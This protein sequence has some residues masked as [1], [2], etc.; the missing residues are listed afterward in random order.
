M[1]QQVKPQL[2]RTIEAFARI[3]RGQRFSVPTRKWI[4]P[5]DLNRSGL[6]RVDNQITTL[7]TYKALEHRMHQ[8]TPDDIHLLC[9][10]LQDSRQPKRFWLW[11]WNNDR[12]VHIV[13]PAG[14]DIKTL[15]GELAK[16]FPNA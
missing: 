11:I 14:T 5:V 1:A 13:E 3:N 8:W 9:A 2:K 10:V 6:L 7:K 4:N 12:G 15:D 16:R